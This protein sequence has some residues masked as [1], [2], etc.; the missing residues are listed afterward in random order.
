[1]GAAASARVERLERCH[2]SRRLRIPKVWRTR[3]RGLRG[4]NTEDTRSLLG[5]YMH[6]AAL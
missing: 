3:G 4:E 6:L 2:L 5:A 1:M